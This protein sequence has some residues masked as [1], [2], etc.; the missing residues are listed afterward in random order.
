MSSASAR[1]AVVLT[2]AAMLVPAGDP[3]AEVRRVVIES[4]STLPA[5]ATGGPAPVYEKLAGRIYYQP[6][7]RG[8]EI[9]IREW[10]AR[11]RQARA[12]GAPTQPPKTTKLPRPPQD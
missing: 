6:S 4:R 2:L 5:P 9:R 8:Y 12:Q 7:E 10:V 1:I 3:R 11:A